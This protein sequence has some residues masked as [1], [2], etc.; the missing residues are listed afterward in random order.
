MLIQ[1]AVAVLTGLVA[2]YGTW[3]L[4]YG[5]LQNPAIVIVAWIAASVSLAV[6][7]HQWR[8]ISRRHRGRQEEG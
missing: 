6:I 2:L 3:Q 7:L 5:S 1:L 4:F 8:S